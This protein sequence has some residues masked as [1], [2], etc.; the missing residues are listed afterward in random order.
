MNYPEAVEKLAAAKVIAE[1]VE[2]LASAI[3]G[4]ESN[5]HS[6][7]LPKG[8]R[9]SLRQGQQYY[10]SVPPN[11]FKHDTPEARY[12]VS[13]TFTTTTFGMEIRWINHL[14]ECVGSWTFTD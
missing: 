7:H 10:V 2:K 6:L 9:E 1:A 8:F 4:H 5:H 3:S 14:G 12:G 11:M 13:C